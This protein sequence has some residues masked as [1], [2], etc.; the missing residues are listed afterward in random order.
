[1]TSLRQS[2][3][4]A[5]DDGVLCELLTYRVAGKVI[6]DRLLHAFL[7][8]F[9][10]LGANDPRGDPAFLVEDADLIER[11]IDWKVP[12]ERLVSLMQ[13]KVFVSGFLQN[14]VIRL[15]GIAGSLE[16]TC[17]CGR[18]PLGYDLQPLRNAGRESGN[19]R[20]ACQYRCA[21]SSDRDRSRRCEG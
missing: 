7:R 6:A 1:M 8:A 21:F 13:R 17:K 10:E 12:Q 5:A 3:D 19:A 2:A 16:R 4:H 18:S 20:N 14:I 15:R 11:G 9:S